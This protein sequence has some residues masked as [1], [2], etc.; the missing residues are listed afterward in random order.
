MAVRAAGA[1]DTGLGRE[2]NEDSYLCEARVFAVADGLGGHAGG[3]IASRLAVEALEALDAGAF[4][5]A[6]AAQAALVDAVHEANR[7]VRQRAQAQP[8]LDGMGTTLTAAVLVG[9]EV[10]LVHVGDSRAY[11]LASGDA[12]LTRLT[13]DH[14][15]VED[16]VRAGKLTAAQ[17]RVHPYRSMLSQAVGLDAELE[18]ETPPAQRLAPGDRLLLCSDGLMEVLDDDAIAATLR[19]AG[20]PE[21]A[22]AAL[23]QATL[24]GGAPDNVTVV[25]VEVADPAGAEPSAST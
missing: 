21:Q 11:L 23:V 16:A 24:D 2:H 5:E 8:N 1:T 9:D 20:T 13:R 12:V 17:A 14:T 15:P 10:A 25:V 22:C 7:R 6:E 19:A 3:E 4:T 18:V